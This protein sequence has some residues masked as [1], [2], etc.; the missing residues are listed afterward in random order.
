MKI[1]VLDGIIGGFK[2]FVQLGKNLIEYIPYYSDGSGL[3]YKISF[4]LTFY[5]L[6]TIFMAILFRDIR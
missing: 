3:G 2:G 4:I 5:F 6:F 1:G